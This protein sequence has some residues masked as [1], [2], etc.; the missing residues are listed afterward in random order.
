MKNER[1]FWNK[2]ASKYDRVEEKDLYVYERVF[3]EIK[4]YLKSD[5]DLLDIGCGTGALHDQM[6]KLVQQV[7]GVDYSENMIQIAKEKAASKNLSNVEYF[8]GT[9]NQNAVKEKSYDLVTAFYLLHLFENIENEL[10]L[11]KE[12]IADQGYFISVTPCMK[13]SGIVGVLLGFSG[14]I[15]LIPKFRHYSQHELSLLLE[16]CGFKIV[17]VKA[18]REKTNEYMIIAQKQ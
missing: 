17:E 12:V 7:V 18:M 2:A 15:G 16:K 3:E 9:L 4:P 14:A 6:S 11:I 10:S 13:D 8:C 5:T 1:K